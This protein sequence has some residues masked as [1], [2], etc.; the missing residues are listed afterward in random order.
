[1]IGTFRMIRAAGPDLKTTGEGAAVDI[2]PR[3]GIV[4]IG[5]LIAHGA[6]EGALNALTLLLARALTPEVRV[7]AIC[8]V[9]VAQRVVERLAPE[10]FAERRARSRPRR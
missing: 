10:S 3:A 5:S 7:S 6:S 9:L 4:G 2:S 8:L 1:M